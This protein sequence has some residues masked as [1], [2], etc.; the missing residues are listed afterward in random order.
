MNALLPAARYVGWFALTLAC[1][2]VFTVAVVS[3]DVVDAL[4]LS[5]GVAWIGT[6]ASTAFLPARART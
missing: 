1:W 6:A 3:L 2:I 4:P 5:L